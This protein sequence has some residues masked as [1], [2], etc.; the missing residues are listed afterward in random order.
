MRGQRHAEEGGGERLE[1]PHQLRGRPRVEARGEHHAHQPGRARRRDAERERPAERL[2][3]EREGPVRR[4]LAQDALG[5]LGVTQ[6]PVGRVRE[7]ARLERAA[8]GRDEAREE[9][10]GPVEAGEQ[11][12][13][14]RRGRGLHFPAV[15]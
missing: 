6:D 4:Q 2:A 9:G 8:A 14:E 10:A 1:Q 5:E 7:D 12:E 3:Q 13:E 15:S 11:E